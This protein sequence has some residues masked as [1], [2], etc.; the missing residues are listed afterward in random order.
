MRTAILYVMGVASGLAMVLT[1]VLTVRGTDSAARELD[2]R[3][4][5]AQIALRDTSMASSDAQ[6]SFSVILETQDQ[7]KRASLLSGLQQA[8]LV[9][10]G[11]W[12]AYRAHALDRPGEAALQQ[13]YATASAR[14]VKLAF[15]VL[16]LAPT[17]P[18]YASTLADERAETAKAQGVLAA[19][20][21]RI[22]DPVMRGQSAAIVSG[23]NDARDAEYLAYGALAL[24]FSIVGV[25]L[26]RG[27]R[28]DDR[29]M[30]TDAATMV[31]EARHANLETSLQRA[32]EMEQTE[33]ATYDII[34]QALTIVAPDVPSEMLLADSSQAHFRQVFSTS[35]GADTACSVGAPGQCPATMTGQTQLFKDSSNLDTCPYLR[36]REDAVWA[37][38]VP[39][40][41]AGRTTGVLHMQRPVQQ[42]PTDVAR[43]WELVARKAGDRLG[44]LRAFARSESQA[45]TD[46][47]TGLLNRRS[48]EARTRD[49]ADEGIP[50]VVAY[51]DLDHFKLLNDVHGHDTGDRALRLFARVLRDSVRPNDIPA[52]YGGEE[53]VAVLPDCLLDN[54]VTIIE[55]IRTRLTQELAEGTVPDFTVSFGLAA[56]ETGLGFGETVD[57]ADQALL[58][59]KRDGRDRIVVAATK[60]TSSYTDPAP[61]TQSPPPGVDRSSSATEAQ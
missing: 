44:M 54:A 52:R 36:G 37:R 61:S 2:R 31:A 53:F 35:P 47:L 1:L 6:E 18:A 21:S 41:I 57:A 24:V 49:L 28:S 17:D 60:A 33:E 23:I 56:S 42:P 14:S 50:Y 40:A 9:E 27:S 4:V 8:G 10:S 30:T 22:Y 26:L 39:I 59:A 58:R 32:L 11:A 15:A 3:A 13:S 34:A 29:R 5:P 55:R 25:W 48:L 45:R 38:C 16:G 46:P 43:A 19:I 12:T 7:T 20:E 51:G